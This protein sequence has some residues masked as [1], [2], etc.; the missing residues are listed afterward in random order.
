MQNASPVNK[1]KMGSEC[2]SAPRPETL[3]QMG[4][5]KNS[6][7]TAECGEAGSSCEGRLKHPR[8]GWRFLDRRPRPIA[9]ARQ[10]HRAATNHDQQHRIQ[11]APPRLPARRPARRRNPTARRECCSR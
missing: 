2:E 6:C 4:I 11:I 8:S 1:K 3:A 10:K 9:G 5:F 7:E